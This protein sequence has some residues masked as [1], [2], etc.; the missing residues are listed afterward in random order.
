MKA[1]SMDDINNAPSAGMS[2]E[3]SDSTPAGFSNLLG[4]RQV[5][6]QHES[7]GLCALSKGNEAATD[8]GG[9]PMAAK[10]GHRALISAMCP[11]TTMTERNRGLGASRNGL[12]PAGRVSPVIPPVCAR[13]AQPECHS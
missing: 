11:R 9:S 13:P 5:H 3:P 8:E 1:T 12:P 10:N 6:A 4:V 2:D 7:L